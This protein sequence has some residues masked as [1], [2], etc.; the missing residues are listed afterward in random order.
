M[1]EAILRAAFIPFGSSLRAPRSHELP[2]DGGRRT[3]PDVPQHVAI[4]SPLY[5]P[6][7]CRLGETC[8]LHATSLMSTFRSTKAHVRSPCLVSVKPASRAGGKLDAEQHRGFGFVEFESREDAA[9]AVDNM[10]NGELYG[11][12]LKER[13]L[14]SLIHDLQKHGPEPTHRKRRWIRIR[15]T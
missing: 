9:T 1:T 15:K 10:N 7:R 12:V 8:G 11:R 14:F 6:F 13:T 4:A 2:C 5:S 3:G